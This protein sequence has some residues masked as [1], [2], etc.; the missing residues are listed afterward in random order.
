VAAFAASGRPLPDALE[1]PEY[2][3]RAVAALSADPNVLAKSGQTLTA[4]ALAAE[5]GFTD[6]DGRRVPPF[7]IEP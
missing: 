6:V 3:G 1:S 7:H 2:V 5:Y 4:G